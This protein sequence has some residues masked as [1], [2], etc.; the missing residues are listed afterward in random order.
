MAKRLGFRHCDSR[1][2]FLWQSDQQPPARWHRE[3]E[4][5]ANYFADTPVGAWAEFLRH[6]DITDPA[7]LDGVRRS[8]WVVELPDEGYAR[9]GLPMRTLTGGLGSYATCQAEARRLR[10]GGA[11]RLEA[12]AAALKPGTARGWIA[13]PGTMPAAEP[14]DGT[15]CVLFGPCAAIGW[16]AVVAGAPPAEV[17]PLVRVL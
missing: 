10:D 16:P 2:P 9:P 7:D 15:V 4:G 5:P 14:R 11:T 6:E 12:P 3:G 17:L 8:P 13:L 1:M